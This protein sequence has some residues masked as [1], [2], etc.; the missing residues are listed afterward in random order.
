MKSDDEVEEHA[1]LCAEG[2]T[3][4]V[5]HRPAHP[6]VPFLV[7]IVLAAIA[8]LIFFRVVFR[9]TL[10]TAFLADVLF[11]AFAIAQ[12]ALL[13]TWAVFGPWRLYAQW[14]AALLVGL[15]LLLAYYLG[16]E[17]VASERFNP[18]GSEF[19][20]EFSLAAMRSLV[21]LAAAQAPLW[22]IRLVRGWRLVP[23][24]ADAA[25]IAV[26]SRQIQLRDILIAMTL[27]ALFLGASRSLSTMFAG[28]EV[29]F[30]AG[31][32]WEGIAPMIGS[33]LVI[34][35][36]LWVCFGS[37]AACVRLLVFVG[38]RDRDGD[39]PVDLGR[40]VGECCVTRPSWHVNL[41]SAAFEFCARSRVRICDDLRG[42][43]PPEARGIG[44]RWESR[45][46]SQSVAMIPRRHGGPALAHASLSHPTRSARSRELVPGLPAG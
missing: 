43:R 42:L 26:E 22:A 7:P 40:S 10:P 29:D 9:T 34:P 28:R 24:G 5:S 33:T 41:G 46:F 36:C 8:N 16:L 21:V 12:F 4:P 32:L 30:L 39:R 19:L 13:A 20:C 44:C 3:A 37:R 18:I 6:F 45:G 23:R 1:K 11:T 2:R 35:I 14:F 31:I 27:L 15:G 25:R 17:L 38:S